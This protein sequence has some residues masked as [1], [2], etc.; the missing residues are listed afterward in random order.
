MRKLFCLALALTV[1]ACA[2]IVPTAYASSNTVTLQ[3]SVFERGNTTNTYGTV[4]DNYWTRWVQKEFGD[5]NGINVEYIPIPRAEESAKLNTLMASN[6]APDIIFSYDTRMIMNYGKDGGLTALDELIAEYGPNITANLAESLPYGGLGGVQYA[7]PAVRAKVG[8]Y[9]NFIR[10]DWLDSLGYELQTGDDGFYHMSVEDLERLLYEAKGTNADGLETF[11]LGVPGAYNATQVKPIVFSFVNRGELTGEQAAAAPQMLWPGFKDGVS[12]LNKLY[13]DKIIDPDFMIDTDTAL[14]SFSTQV[15]TSRTLAYGQDDF[16][17]TGVQALYDGTPEAEVV[18]FQLDNL[19]GEPVNTVYMPVG[20]YVAVPASSKNPDAAVKY[21]N[22][23]ADYDT[24]H[25]LSY[26]FEGVHYEMIDGTPASILYS[27]EEK[28]AIEGYERITTGDMN[29]M[30]NG[31]PFGYMA[32]TIGV[33][34]SERRCILLNDIASKLSPVG[35]IPEYYFQ[36]VVTE[37]EEMYDGFVPNLETSL[38]KLIAAPAG[39]FDALWDSVVN[40]YLS[41]GGQEIIDAK[42]ALYAELEAAK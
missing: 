11:P 9:T 15:S 34:E 38:P 32:S 4:S 24:C 35:G 25:V 27:D 16:Y 12:F 14:P 13:N 23:L 28:A 17:K 26:G 6:S 37:A 18:A 5:P 19:Y 10:K 22:F 1:A 3:V 30:F 29:L 20:F 33:T 41:A 8:R 7:I 21:L 31:Q 39:E 42:T 40:E 2:G 36:G